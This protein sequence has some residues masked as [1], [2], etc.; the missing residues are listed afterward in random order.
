MSI[1]LRRP[2]FEDIKDER[3]R[4]SVQWLYEYLIAEP[5]LRGKFE[6]FEITTKGAVTALKI[7]HNLGFQ[8][9]DIIK[10]SE[11][12]GTTT[13]LYSSFTTQY[14]VITTTA[15]LTVRF[16]GGTYESENV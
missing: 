9:K 4:E 11:I 7:P 1:P 14:I 13:F 8:P 16:F 5:I 3:V 12:G 10:T 15:A 6:F 2:I